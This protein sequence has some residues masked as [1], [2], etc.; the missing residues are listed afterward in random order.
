[1]PNMV[2]FVS[3]LLVIGLVILFVVKNFKHKL[4]LK[5][6]ERQLKLVP[7]LIHLPPSTDD[8]EVGGRDERDIN[9]EAISAATIMYS[10]IAST[11]KKNNFNTK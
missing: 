1:M 11:I 5:N 4:K 7:L 9:D 2:I 6:Y 10:I 8:I 3:A